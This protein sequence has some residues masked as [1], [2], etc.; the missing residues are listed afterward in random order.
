M[1][2]KNMTSTPVI[3]KSFIPSLSEKVSINFRIL[4]YYLLTKNC[5]IKK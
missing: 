2:S 1:T 3:F 5:S 4:S